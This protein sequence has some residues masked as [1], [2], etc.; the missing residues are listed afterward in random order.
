[1]TMNV[2]QVE[3]LRYVARTSEGK[4][5]IAEPSGMLGGKD[6]YPNPMEYFVASIG[7]CIA[8]KTQINLPKAGNEPDLIGIEMN[9][10]RSQT[11]PEVLEAIHIIITVSGDL[12]ETVVNR[13]VQDTMTL[14]CPVN[15]MV[16]RIARVTWEYRIRQPDT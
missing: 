9:C 12:D 5:I 10:T 1:M 15:V 4:E 7:T 2:F 8:I 14:S 6:E 13:A 11:P 16:S 3:P